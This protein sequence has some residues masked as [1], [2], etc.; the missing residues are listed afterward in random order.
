MSAIEETNLCLAKIGLGVKSDEIVPIDIGFEKILYSTNTYTNRKDENG[1]VEVVTVGRD[2]S[3]KMKHVTFSGG[4]SGFMR[5]VEKLTTMELLVYL[6]SDKYLCKFIAD[7]LYFST[8]NN[9][10][11]VFTMDP[12]EL[13]TDNFRNLSLEQIKSLVVQLTSVLSNIRKKCDNKFH[14]FLFD[15]NRI[16][17]KYVDQSTQIDLEPDGVAIQSH[18]VQLK[19]YNFDH[20]AFE[21]NVKK[22]TYSDDQTFSRVEERIYD[23]KF[24]EFSVDRERD[25]DLEN[26]IVS[27]YLEIIL[28]LRD[29]EVHST[30]RDDLIKIVISRKFNPSNNTRRSSSQKQVA[31]EE[32]LI[33]FINDTVKNYNLLYEFA[34]YRDISVDDI[35]NILYQR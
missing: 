33:R 5:T 7:G 35:L 25:G 24:P 13:L 34:P 29:S 18:G 22:Q 11:T 28:L 14:I 1:G 15:I 3:S 30:L 20:M 6:K 4:T 17:F 8:D 2:I 16:G 21:F 10:K 31:N 9:G 32:D 19:L 27:A 23:V 12:F 26:T